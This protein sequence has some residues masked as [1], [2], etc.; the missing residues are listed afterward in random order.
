MISDCL[1]ARDLLLCRGRIVLH[2]LRHRFIDPLIELVRVLWRVECLGR[3]AAP[4]L[5]FGRH[6]I[7]VQVEAADGYRARRAASGF[8]SAPVAAPAAPAAAIAP[9]VS[10]GAVRSPL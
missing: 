3:F 10:P 8:H 4:D 9:I 1:A 6:V 5:L 7:H 2:E